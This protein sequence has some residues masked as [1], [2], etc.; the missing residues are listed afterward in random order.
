VLG[1]V[2]GWFGIA[3]EGA[4]GCQDANPTDHPLAGRGMNTLAAP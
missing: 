4:A 3:G 1:W 2:L